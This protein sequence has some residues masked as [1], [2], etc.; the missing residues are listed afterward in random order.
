MQCLKTN[1]SGGLYTFYLHSTLTLCKSKVYLT[2]SGNI[3][4]VGSRGYF[5]VV[6][7]KRSNK[8]VCRQTGLEVSLSLCLYATYS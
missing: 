2:S 6:W 1:Y 4:Q 7:C 5:G 8:K 3:T